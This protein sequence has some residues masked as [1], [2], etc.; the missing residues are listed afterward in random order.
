MEGLERSEEREMGGRW[1]GAAGESRKRSG[2]WLP[3]SLSWLV[4]WLA[5]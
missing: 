2:F 4:G 3:R 5:S 1:S